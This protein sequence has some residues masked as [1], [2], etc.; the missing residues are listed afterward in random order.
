MFGGNEFM[1]IFFNNLLFLID[2]NMFLIYLKY[3]QKKNEF[4]LGI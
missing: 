3:Q 4:N 2:V 1:E